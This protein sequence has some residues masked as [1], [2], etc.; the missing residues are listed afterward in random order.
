MMSK[1]LGAGYAPIED[2]R[3]RQK[4]NRVCLLRDIAG[5]FSS[6]FAVGGHQGD[7]GA[8]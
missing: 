4:E 5:S 2:L 7:L 3:Y 6:S 8:P 1:W